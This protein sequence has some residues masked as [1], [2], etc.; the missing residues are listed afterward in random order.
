[1]PKEYLDLKM[2][3]MF[4]Q[5]FGHPSRKRITMAFL[6]GLLNRTGRDRIVDV[7]SE[8]TELP[9]ETED[10]KMSRLDVLVF[11]D[12][13]ERINVEIQ[14]VH[15]HDMPE[16]VLYYWARL[17]SSSL[18]KGQEYSE[19][20]PTIMLTILNYPLFPHE[21]D[22]FHTVFHIREDEEHFL[23]SAHLEFHAIDLSQ[24]MVK[25]KK[26][27]KEMKRSSEWPWLMMLSAVDVRKREVD[28]GI[29][30]ELEVLAMNEQEIREALEEWEKLSVSPE[31]RYAYE[32]RLKW[33]RDQLSNIRGERRAGMEEG[34]KQGLEQG[35]KQKERE[36]IRKM[37]AK[38]MSITEIAHM[39]DLAEE[40]I[41]KILKD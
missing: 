3:F 5:L 6:N 34:L 25:W 24:F 11:T 19:L 12:L 20:S 39:L 13:G 2:D 18:S 21:T 1:M 15:Q 41:H 23:W 4:K 8:N 31:N 38:G 22:S 30:N 16:R 10:G 26:Y 27:R 7:Q 37:M 35:M 33:L 28:E 40:E 14:V 9:K 17:F 32:M 36:L 29:L